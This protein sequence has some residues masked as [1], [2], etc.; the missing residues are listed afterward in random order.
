MTEEEARAWLQKNGWLEGQAGQRLEKLAALLIAENEHQN[1][2]SASSLPHLWARHIVDS[3]QLLL[4]AQARNVGDGL[5][6]DLGSGAG[7]PGLVVAC[8]R[9]AP[10]AL[11]ETRG[12]RVRYLEN[13]IAELGLNHAHVKQAK[14]ERVGLDRRASIISA[15]AFASL[16]ATFGMASHLCDR[17]TLWLLPKG[18]SAQLE[19]ESATQQWQAAFHVEQSATDADSAI[20]IATDVRH[21]DTSAKHK[22]ARGRR[23]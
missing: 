17:K 20:I 2:V 1:L 11:V 22:S 8:L 3:A 10:M 18:R 12:L 23:A 4:L 6:V 15:R 14:V 16:E 13:C 7:F 21:R 19:L 9:D 5:W